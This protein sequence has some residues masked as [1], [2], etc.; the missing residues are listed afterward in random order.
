MKWKLPRMLGLL[1]VAAGVASLIGFAVGGKEPVPT[2][3]TA[4]AGA[5][6]V[7]HS[8]QCGCCGDWIDYLERHGFEVTSRHT[9]DLG[10]VKAEYGVDGQLEACHTAV[11]DGYVV[12]GHVPAEEIR[13]ML[14]EQPDIRGLAVPGMPHGSPGMEGPRN[15]AY[16]VLQFTEDGEI[17]TFSERQ[18]GD[19]L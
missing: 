1:V 8:P 3:S 16:K 4:S 14:A 11:I 5:I 6:E 2:S 10:P 12:E 19:H 13:Q 9:E 15:E 17:A 7:Y 18:G